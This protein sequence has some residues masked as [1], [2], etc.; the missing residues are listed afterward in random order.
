MYVATASAYRQMGGGRGDLANLPWPLAPL[1][2]E[3]VR[4]IILAVLAVAALI[5]GLVI[6][7]VPRSGVTLSAAC[8]HTFQALDQDAARELLPLET[9]R[10]HADATLMECRTSGEWL[11]GF[12]AHHAFTLGND[13]P[14]LLLEWCDGYRNNNPAFPACDTS[15][16][17][18]NP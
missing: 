4:R 6:W 12:A 10:A 5:A 17:P 16:V 2:L 9:Q 15:S 8:A 3:M 1:P 7:V 11:R 13:G 18:T 14:T